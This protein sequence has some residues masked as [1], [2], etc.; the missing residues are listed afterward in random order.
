ME[1]VIND[2]IKSNENKKNKLTIWKFFAYFIIYS[3]L[4]WIIETAYGFLIEGVIESRKSFLYGP[5]CAIYGVGASIMIVLLRYF[6]KNNYTLFFAG[7]VIG[8]FIEYMVSWIGELWLHTRW[9][10]YS[11]QFLNIN[12]RICLS[13]TFFWGILAIILIKTINP[14]IDKF[15]DWMLSKINPK[16]FNTIILIFIILIFFDWIYSAA[17]Q[18]WVLIKVSVEK[19]LNIADK[20]K[21]KQKYEEV[22]SNENIKNF[23][24]KYW[25]IEKFLYAFPNATKEVE[26]G[27]RVY[28]KRLYPEIHPYLIRIKQEEGDKTIYDS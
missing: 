20:D 12:G 26:D 8:S 25:T 1:E 4:G 10:D 21:A 22:Y 6:D 15:I 23:V 11:G 19:E 24:D 27:K 7:T 5:L 2:S 18:E 17:V 13:Y 14:R 3:F 28:I 9:W 16:I